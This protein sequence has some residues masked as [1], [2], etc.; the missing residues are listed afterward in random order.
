MANAAAIVLK[1]ILIILH[2]LAGNMYQRGKAASETTANLHVI[3][4]L[5]RCARLPRVWKT[6]SSDYAEFI[7]IRTFLIQLRFREAA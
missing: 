7:R 4:S 2:H 1:F 3:S 5:R 6:A